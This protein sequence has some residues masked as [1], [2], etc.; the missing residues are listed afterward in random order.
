MRT[1][2]QLRTPSKNR[3]R[4]QRQETWSKKNANT[5]E[6]KLRYEKHHAHWHPHSPEENKNSG[7]H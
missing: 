4:Y 5:K 3:V 6:D 1:Q 7:K 2:R